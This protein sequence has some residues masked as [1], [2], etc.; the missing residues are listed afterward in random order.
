MRDDSAAE[1]SMNKRQAQDVGMH[2]VDA[3]TNSGYGA[4]SEAELFNG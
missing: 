3:I 4:V 1:A 2:A